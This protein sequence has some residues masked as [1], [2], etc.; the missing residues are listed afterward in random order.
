MKINLNE[1]TK[2]FQKTADKQDDT[3]CIKLTGN[4]EI[5]IETACV[6]CLVILN[7]SEG[8]FLVIEE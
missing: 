2:I 6:P 5:N 3:L 8:T 7:D 1:I 4:F